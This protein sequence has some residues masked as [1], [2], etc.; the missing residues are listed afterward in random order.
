MRVVVAVRRQKY[1]N[2]KK[3][4]GSVDND[5]FSIVLF[6]VWRL[7]AEYM[8]VAVRKCTQCM[9]GLRISILQDISKQKHAWFDGL[10]CAFC[11][12][13]RD[14]ISCSTYLPT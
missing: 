7:F 2:K 6:G 11:M 4:N 14:G 3:T 9:Y 13:R 12:S 8:Y 5:S 1:P 10:F